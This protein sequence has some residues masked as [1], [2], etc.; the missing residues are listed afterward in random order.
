MAASSQMEYN[1]NQQNTQL[2]LRVFE[3][4]VLENDTQ[5]QKEVDSNHFM[6]KGLIYLST[7]AAL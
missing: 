3:C 4:E 1:S 5:R 2:N 7:C 6:P